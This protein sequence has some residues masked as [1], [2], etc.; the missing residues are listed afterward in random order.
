VRDAAKHRAD[1]LR[2]GATQAATGEHRTEDDLELL[3]GEGHSEAPTKTLTE[4]ERKA[5]DSSSP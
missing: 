3:E 4:R 5:S 1:A 2:I